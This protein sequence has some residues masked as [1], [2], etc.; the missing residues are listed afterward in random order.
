MRSLT[1]SNPIYSARESLKVLF[2]ETRKKVNILPETADCK[3][4]N[5]ISIVFFLQYESN[6]KKL[7]D[8][9]GP[10]TTANTNDEKSATSA[11]IDGPLRRE[12][13]I[14]P[15]GGRRIYR[16]A[17]LNPNTEASSA[18]EIAERQLNAEI[19]SLDQLA[20]SISQL[21]LIILCS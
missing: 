12:I 21:L 1:A 20:V 13:W 9:M 17:S 5:L 7:Q 14:H 11:L 6:L 16:T 18:A 19:N 3:L 4:L 15:E 10:I 2:D 8:K